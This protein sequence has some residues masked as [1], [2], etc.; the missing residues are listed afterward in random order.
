MRCPN[1]KSKNVT[2]LDIALAHCNNCGNVYDPIVAKYNYFV[3]VTSKKP[4]SPSWKNYIKALLINALIVFVFF[5]LFVG[6]LL[7]ID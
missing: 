3:P 6:L 1:C 5:V 2:P 4:L 7:L